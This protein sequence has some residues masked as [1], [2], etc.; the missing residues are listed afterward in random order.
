MDS[1]PKDG[2]KAYSYLYK[3]KRWKQLR[4]WVL[5]KEPLCQYCLKSGFINP[6]EV[7]DHI[8]PH[9]GKHSKFFSRKNLRALCNSC[10]SSLKQQE[11]HNG[12]ASGCDENGDPI[13]NKHWD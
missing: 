10:H 7:V 5:D 12:Y 8:E 13:L 1:S 4:A 2:R 9:K 6:A 3:R 11:E